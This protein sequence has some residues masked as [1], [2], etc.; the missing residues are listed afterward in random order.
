MAYP[1]HVLRHSLEFSS[2]SALHF[3]NKSY[4]HWWDLVGRIRGWNN[5]VTL[6]NKAD[7]DAYFPL[8]DGY[9]GKKFSLMDFSEHGFIS[10]SW[11]QSRYGFSYL[12]LPI[13]PRKSILSR[14][15][16][17]FLGFMIQ[18]KAKQEQERLDRLILYPFS[19]ESVSVG[20]CPKNCQ[21]DCCRSAPY[22]F[23]IY[24]SSSENTV[25]TPLKRFGNRYFDRAPQKST[26]SWNIVQNK[27]NILV[28][29]S[30]ILHFLSFL[31]SIVVSK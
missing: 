6:V 8:S 15:E 29:G 21:S 16:D 9:G 22:G 24:F 2:L 23:V 7:K 27:N 18:T 14:E 20:Y 12:Y 1:A 17:C 13:T 10:W 11:S 4:P 25:C 5:I 19:E 30:F 26:M 28:N 31:R 3:Q